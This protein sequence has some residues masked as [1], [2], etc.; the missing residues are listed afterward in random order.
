MA[1]SCDNKM[2]VHCISEFHEFSPFFSP[3]FFGQFSLFILNHNIFNSFTFLFS[4]QYQKTLFYVRW[5]HLALIVI[6]I[7]QTYRRCL[8]S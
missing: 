3:F 1:Q 4:F 2:R 8:F 6:V 7:L 5:L